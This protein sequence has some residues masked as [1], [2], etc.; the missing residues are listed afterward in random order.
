MLFWSKLRT[1]TVWPR[2]EQLSNVRIGPS[3]HRQPRRK[4]SYDV[5]FLCMF[6]IWGIKLTLKI[7]QNIL[8]LSH[9]II[10]SLILR[11]IC[12]PSLSIK[13]PAKKKRKWPIIVWDNDDGAPGRRI[14]SSVWE[15][16]CQYLPTT[17]CCPGCPARLKSE[18]RRKPGL[19][20]LSLSLG[21]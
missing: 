20:S 17:E 16:T 21:S 5:Q 12:L 15:G 14:M 11:R 3:H 6:N 8:F 19:L 18:N 10:C 1:C 4:L 9:R 2:S 7:S 13:A